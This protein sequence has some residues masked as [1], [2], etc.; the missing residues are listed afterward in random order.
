[1]NLLSA[2]GPFWRPPLAAGATNYLTRCRRDHPGHFS[3]RGAG[4]KLQAKR[5]MST[6]PCACDLTFC[7]CGGAGT[8]G[9][10]Q[11]GKGRG[12]GPLTRDAGISASSPA[13]RVGHGAVRPPRAG[14]GQGRR[15]RRGA[16][17]VR[18]ESSGRCPRLSA[19]PLQ[20]M[21]CS[22]RSGQLPRARWPAVP[23]GAPP[24]PA[25]RGVQ[26][27]PTEPRRALQRAVS[28]GAP[29]RPTHLI[30]GRRS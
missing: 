5:K 25:A 20:R 2:L 14:G 8:E 28:G 11:P 19:D 27:C 17:G 24:R 26:R 1:M 13:E 30:S 29:R 7:P 21:L 15:S 3:G 9:G 12:S 6:T 23:R 4:R 16:G 10:R 18:P 22:R